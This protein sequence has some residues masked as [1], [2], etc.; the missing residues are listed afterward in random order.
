VRPSASV[1]KSN[2]Y[3]VRVAVCDRLLIR[4]LSALLLVFMHD[5]SAAR[6][7]PFIDQHYGAA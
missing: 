3:F 7:K 6:G 4:S 5:I 2:V 1:Q